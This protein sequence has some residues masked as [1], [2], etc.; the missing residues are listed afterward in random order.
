MKLKELYTKYGLNESQVS[1]K[2]IKRI[3]QR[4]SGATGD[5]PLRLFIGSCPDYTNDGTNY[6]FQG[7]SSGIPL[8]TSAQLK[9]NQALFQRLEHLWRTIQLQ[10][11]ACRH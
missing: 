2:D 8:L 5:V 4:A 10:Y 11:S 9:I 3:E 7:V 6:T 1:Q